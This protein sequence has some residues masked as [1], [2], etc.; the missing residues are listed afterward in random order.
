MFGTGPRKNK[1]FFDLTIPVVKDDS[2]RKKGL[3]KVLR[4]TKQL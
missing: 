1:C 3:E 4:D 2:H